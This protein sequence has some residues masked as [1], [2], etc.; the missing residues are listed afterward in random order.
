MLACLLAR[1]EVAIFCY[2]A[3]LTPPAEGFPWYN[4]RKTFTGCQRM[5]KVP[6]AV[7]ILPKI[8]T[9]WVGR[10]NVTADR[11]TTDGRAIAYSE[12]ER[13][14]AKNSTPCKIVT[15]EN[16]ILKL[17]TRDYVDKVTYYTIFDADRFSGGFSPNRPPYVRFLHLSEG[18]CPT[19]QLGTWGIQLLIT[20]S[21]THTLDRRQLCCVTSAFHKARIAYAAA[22]QAYQQNLFISS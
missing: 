12:R 3:C 22:A 5:A 13:E 7:E 10:M 15:T 4:L 18:H 8:W 1:Y 2:P 19:E 17:G 16:F 14:F 9:A 11:Q 20:V 21:H 6:N